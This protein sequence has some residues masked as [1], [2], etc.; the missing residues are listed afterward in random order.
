MY[1]LAPNAYERCFYC[2]RALDFSCAAVVVGGKEPRYLPFPE[3]SRG[4]LADMAHPKC[5]AEAEGL[6]RFLEVLARHDQR[7]REA[8]AELRDRLA[9]GRSVVKRR[10]E[11]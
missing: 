4:G 6:D 5:F 2:T 11:R 9:K 7:Q 8:L 1:W 10:R 3:D